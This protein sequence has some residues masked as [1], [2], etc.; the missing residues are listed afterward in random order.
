MNKFRQGQ[1]DCR[2]LTPRVNLEAKQCNVIVD[3]MLGKNYLFFFYYF[4]FSELIQMMCYIEAESV[5]IDLRVE[6]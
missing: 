5:M 4:Y 2:Q 3:K 1:P 6:M